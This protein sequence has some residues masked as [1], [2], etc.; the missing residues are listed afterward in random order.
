MLIATAPTK[1][2]FSAYAEVFLNLDDYVISKE[3]FLC[4][5][6][7]VSAVDDLKKAR[8]YFSLPTQRCFRGK[9]FCGY[10]YQ[11]FSAYAEVFPHVYRE[12]NDTD[13]FLCLRRGVSH[14]YRPKTRRPKLFSAY[15]EVFL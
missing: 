6:R 15:A 10:C 4:L 7:G 12:A 3:A 1:L 2:L 13:T 9:R 8:W 11:L 5:R 14:P